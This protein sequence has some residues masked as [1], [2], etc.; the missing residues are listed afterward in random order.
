MGTADLREMKAHRMDSYGR[1]FTS[2]GRI[3]GMVGTLLFLAL[4]VYFVAKFFLSPWG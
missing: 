2:A 3:L 4:G 1:K